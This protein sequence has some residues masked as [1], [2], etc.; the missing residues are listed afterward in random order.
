MR[1]HWTAFIP[2]LVAG[3]A[4]SSPV[5]VS[6][7]LPPA[8]PVAVAAQPPTKLVETRYDVRGY[9]EAAAPDLRHEPHAVFRRT[10]LPATAPDDCKTVPRVSAPALTDVPLPA[11][12]ELEAELATQRTVTSEIR[13]LQASMAET[14]RRMQA[15][16]AQLV[17]QS[18][19]V[20]KVRDQLDAERQRT[21]GP[22]PGSP[23]LTSTPAGADAPAEV[24]W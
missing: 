20:M 18:A 5:A 2:L 12:T 4:T 21:H 7:S 8:A 1:L 19:E 22:A 24:K 13:A 23:S 16:Y 9:R 14:E 6:T 11:S 3:C 10:R 15:Q 17:R